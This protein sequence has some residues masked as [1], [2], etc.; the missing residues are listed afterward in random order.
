MQNI[1]RRMISLICFSLLILQAAA[2]QAQTMS[3]AAPKEVGLSAARLERIDQAVKNAIARNEVAGGVA[4]VARRRKVAYLRSFG[5]M[6]R[7]A[8]KPMAHDT[9]FRIASM[10][11]AITSTAVMILVEEGRLGLNDPVAKYLPEFKEMKVLVPS[12]DNTSD[13]SSYTLVP[14]NNPITVRH[15]LT[16]TSGISYRFNRSKHLGE[17]YVKAGISDGLSQT[18]GA[19]GDMVKKLAK[20]PLLHQ[21]GERWTYSLSVDVLGRLVEVASGKPLDRFFAERIFGPLG[22]WDTHFF[23]PKEKAARLAAVYTP[24]GNGNIRKIGEEETITSGPLVWSASYPYRG[25]RTYFSGG[26][27]LTSTVHDYWRFLQMFLNGGTLDGEMILSR[28]TVEIMTVNHIGNFETFP[29]GAGFGLGFAV[30][31]DPGMSGHYGSVGDYHWSGFFNTSFWAD[32]KEELIGIL[33][34]Q[35]HPNGQSDLLG[36]FRTAV[37]QSVAD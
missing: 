5:M 34:T 14:A 32:P 12:E 16:H 13:D 30:H 19:I 9:I 1:Y 33:M 31:L 22:M 20:L 3:K 6:D 28:K 4:L 36:K 37:Y 15:L 17:L 25:P 10:T 27:G 11:K 35:L 23:L 2:A 24:E 29:E 8:K 7:E 21:P 26:A 18:E